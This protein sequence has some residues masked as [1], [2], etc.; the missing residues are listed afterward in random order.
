MAKTKKPPLPL[1]KTIKDQIL[2]YLIA[3][4]FLAW[5]QNQGMMIT[6]HKG[7]ERAVRFSTMPGISDLQAIRN[8]RIVFIEVK[9]SAKEELRSDQEVFL[10]AVNR[11]GGIGFAAWSI[12]M[13]YETLS[14]FFPMIPP[15]LYYN[16][17]A[18]KAI[19][20]S[21]AIES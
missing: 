15:E 11:Y 20:A 13:V 16:L 10:G 4:Q 6:E 1:E 3:N 5:I 19:F 8:G 7:K 17:V 14:R 21:V 2:A 18:Q 9:R 12:E